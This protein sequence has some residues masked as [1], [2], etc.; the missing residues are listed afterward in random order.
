MSKR[1][2]FSL[3]G[4]N[5]ADSSPIATFRANKKKAFILSEKKDIYN[6]SQNV[7]TTEGTTGRETLIPP[8]CLQVHRHYKTSLCAAELYVFQR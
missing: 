6:L 2:A 4:Q 8:V 3:C 7:I 1:V 5:E